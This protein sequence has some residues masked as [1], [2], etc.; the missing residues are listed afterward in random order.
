MQRSA[1]IDLM[2]DGQLNWQDIFRPFSEIFT[3]ITPGS[4]SR[5]FDNNTFYRKPVV[6]DKVSVGNRTAIDQYFRGDILPKNQKKAIL[7]GPLTFACASQNET[8]PNLADLIDDL[9][10]ALSQIAIELEQR[11]YGYLQFSEPYLNSTTSK[12]NLQSA[13]NAYRTL[14]RSGMKSILHTYFT[15]AGEIIVDLLDFS[16]DCIGIDFYATPIKSILQ[17]SFTK[18]LNCGCIDGRNSLIEST[19]DLRSL[20][21]KLH[22]AISPNALYLSPNCDLEFLPSK[23]AEKK[24]RLLAELKNK[25]A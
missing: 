12:D 8:Y 17:Y 20:V 25:L 21:E 11:G 1:G 5:W 19:Q 9:A 10:H 16:V 3:G 14:K 13:K 23:I 4:L 24:T 18:E 7:P 6:K 22:T 2:V 15:D